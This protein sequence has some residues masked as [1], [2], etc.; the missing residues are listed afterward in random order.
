MSDKINPSGSNNFTTVDLLP[1]YYQTDD[2]KKF[3]QATLDQ[4]A[5]KGT[6]K[7]V[8][9]YIGRKN[10]KSASGK[11]IYVNAVNS[12][13]QN[14]QLEPSIVIKDTSDSVTF[15]K[16][17]QD[18]IN[19][20]DIFGGNTTNHER[21]NRQE[22]YSWDPHIDWDKFV[23]FQQYYWLPYGPDLVA[24]SGQQLN[25][26]STYTVELVQS[27]ANT[28]DYLFT[29]NGI[30]KDPTLTLYRGQTYYFEINSPGEPFSIKTAR[31]TG[32]S[33]RYTDGNYIDNFGVT[34]GTIKFTVPLDSPDTL[35][36]VSEQDPDLGGL[37]KFA[38]IDENTYI[39]VAADILGKKTYTLSNGTALSNGMKVSF[40]GNVTPASYATGE[41][42]VE[43]VGTAIK[44]VPTSI[45]EI[46]SSYTSDVSVLFDSTLFDQYPF[47]AADS[48]AGDSDYIVIN[49]SSADRNP[50]SRYNRWFHKD[51]IAASAAYNN[52]L[53]DL[54]QAKRAARPIIEFEANLK[55]FNFGSIAIKDV[56][57]IDTYTKD[58]FTTIEGTAGYNIDGVQLTEGMRVMFVADDDILV[59]NNIYKVHFVNLQNTGIGVPQIQL[60]LEETPVEN[61]TVIIRSGTQYQGLTFWYTG[62]EW[63]FSQQKTKVNQ[64]PL[65]DLYDADLNSFS[66]YSGSTFKGTKLFSYTE[67]TS[68]VVDTK[69]GFKLSYQN[70]NNIG[71]ILFTFN[72]LTD[73]FEY[74]N[75]DSLVSKVVNTGYLLKLSF[76]NETT[77]V[78]GWQTSQVERYQPAVRVYKDSNKVNDFA[79]DIYDNKADLADLEV[80]VYVNGIRIDSD[81]WTI[82]DTVNYKQIKLATDIS[83][84][85]VLTIKAFARQP[86]NENGY[87]ELPINLQNNPL[88]SD[89]ANFTL[90]EVTD[91]VNSIVDNIQERFVGV[92]SGSNNLRDLGNVTPYG[93][94]FV[95][96]S[97][98][99][100]L[101]LYHITSEQ[102]N[103]VKAIEKS[104][105]DYGKFKRNFLLTAFQLGEDTNTVNQVDTILQKL[106]ANKTKQSP[107]YFSDMVPFGGKKE[108]TYV[109]EDLTIS[110]Y[111]LTTAFDNNVLSTQAVSVYVNGEQ[112][113]YERD[114]TFTTT[115]YVSISKTLVEGDN[116][117]IYEYDSTDGSYIPSTPTK[118]GLW[119]KYEPKIYRDTSLLTPKW[120]IQCHDGSQVLAYGTYGTGGTPDYRDALILELEKRIYNNLQVNYDSSIFDIYKVIPGYY[121]D[122]EY[123]IDEFNTAIAPS[124]YKW[125]TLAGQDFS[126]P[127]EFIQ[128]NTFTY[129]FRN[130]TAP[131][132]RPLPGYW[133]GIY[134]WVYD[135]DRPNICPWE[136]LGFTEEPA[137]WQSVYGPAPY[138]SNNSIMW[139]D[140]ASGAVKE[141]G[142]SVEYRTQFAR[143]DLIN[144]I[145]VDESG[146]LVSP[147]V[148]R[149]SS[150][151]FTTDATGNYVAG[152][153]GPVEAAWRR[154][155]YYSFS[156]LI[157]SMLLKPAY[158]FATCLDRS[159]TIR[160][161]CGQLVYKDTGLRVKPADIVLPSIYTSSTRKY[162]AGIINYLVDL[163]TFNNVQY[164]TDY[165]YNLDNL[166]VKLSYRIAGFTSKENLNLILD[167]KNPSS[168]GNVFVPQENFAIVYNSSSPIRK[169][170]YSGVIV[171]RVHDGFEIKGY[172]TSESYFKYCPP[173]QQGGVSVNVGGIS[174]PFLQWTPNKNYTV[175]QI[176]YANGRYYRTV[177]NVLSQDQFDPASFTLIPALP[178]V[179][180]EDAVF[181]KTWDTDTVL[182]LAYGSVLPTIQS[183]VDF[184]LGYGEYLKSQGFIFDSFNNELSQVTNWETSAKEFMFWTT[185]KWSTGQDKWD[186]WTPNT[187]IAYGAIVKY[188]NDY[189]K[190]LVNSRGTEEFVEENFEK[191]EG[192]STIG[193]AVISLSPAAASLT[194]KSELSVADDINNPFNEYEIFKVD[195]TGLNPI[196]LNCARQ[197]NLVTY[198][199]DGTGTIYN[200]SFYLVQ[201][202]QVLIL[203]N[204]TVFNDVLYHPESGYRQE[205]IKLAG[206]VSS[207]WFGGFEVPGFIFDRAEVKQWAQ[208][209]DYALGDIVQSQGFYYSA[210]GFIPGTAEFEAKDWTQITKPSPKLLP[211]WNYKANQFEDFYDLENDSFDTGQQQ[212]SQ[213]LV[214]YQP[215][216]YLSNIIQDEISEFQ[217][218]QG[219]IREKGTQNSLNKLFDV[220]SASNKESLS[221]YEE[222]A[223]RVGQYGASKA[224]DAVEFVIE[225]PHSSKHSLGY[226]LTQQPS[227]EDPFVVNIA[228]NDVYLKP[229]GYNSQPWPTNNNQ[230][231]YLRT[232]GHVDSS[233]NVIQLGSIDDI[234]KVD[235]KSLREGAYVWTSFDKTSWNIFRFTTS[236]ISPV[237]VAYDASAKSIT[238][239]TETQLDLAM[240]GQYV[241]ISQVDFAGFYKVTD[242]QLTSFTV[243]SDAISIPT[244]EVVKS[245][246]EIFR[247][248][249]VRANSIDDANSIIKSYTTI[250]SKIWVDSNA[251]GKWATLELQSIY[252]QNK[253]KK[254]YPAEN[255]EHG[256]VVV[257]NSEGTLAAVT[258]RVGQVITYEKQ[259]T[260]WVFK[261]LIKQGF[262]YKQE[263]ELENFN[264]PDMFAEALAMSHDGEFLAIGIPRA[265]KLA[266]ITLPNGNV[267]CD[268]SATNAT[269]LQTGVVSVYQK[270][271]YNEYNLLFSI[272]S[273]DNIAD[274]QF[275]SSL[276]FGNNSLF[277]GSKGN[278]NYGA[279]SAVF[280]LRLTSDTWLLKRPGI[281]IINGASAGFGLAI[282]VTRDNAVVAISA[283]YV[284]NVY[285]YKLNAFGAYTLAQTITGSVEQLSIPT[286]VNGVDF[287]DTNTLV[288]GSGFKESALELTTAYVE[289]LETDST[290][291]GEGLIVDATVDAYGTIQAVHIR[292]AGNN[293]QVGDSIKI[294]NPLGNGAVTGFDL[295]IL[296]DIDFT[297]SVGTGIATTNNGSGSGLV[298][299]VAS[300]K[301]AGANIGD[302]VIPVP[303]IASYQVGNGVFAN[304]ANVFGKVFQA[305][306][307]VNVSGTGVGAK[308]DITASDSEYLV[309]VALVDALRVRGTGYQVNN[310][311]RILGTSLGGATPANDAVVT[312]NTIDGSGG[313]LTASITGASKFVPTITELSSVTFDGTVDGTTLTVN[314]INDGTDNITAYIN[315]T[316]TGST[317][318]IF[319]IA[320][321]SII[322][323]MTLSGVGVSEGT[324][325][326]SGSGNT[327]QV[328]SDQTLELMSMTAVL[329]GRL[330]VGMQLTNPVL[331]GPVVFDA[332]ITAGGTTT[333][334]GDVV[335]MT[336]SEATFTGSVKGLN[337]TLNETAP[338]GTIL[339]NMVLTATSGINAGTR[340][341]SGS[342]KQWVLDTLQTANLTTPIPSVQIIDTYGTLKVTSGDYSVGQAITVTGA[343]T[344]G[345][346]NGYTSGT[347]YYIG[348]VINSKT[349]QLTSTYAD[350]ISDAPEMEVRTPTGI[351]AVDLVGLTFDGMTIGSY[352]I[353]ANE[354][355]PPYFGT[356]TKP[357]LNF[358]VTSA[359]FGFVEVVTAGS[360]YLDAPV[361]TPN[362][363][364]LAGGTGAA[365]S[366]EVTLQL[367]QTAT[368]G[369]VFGLATNLQIQGKLSAPTIVGNILTFG[370]TTGTNNATLSE[371]MILSGG[372]VL[373]GTKVITGQG[374]IWYV[375]KSQTAT[376]TTATSPFATITGNRL[377]FQSS[378]GST[379][380]IGMAL[381]GGTVEPGTYITDGPATDGGITF[382]TVNNNQFT[383]CTTATK[384]AFFID[385]VINGT[386][387]TFDTTSGSPIEV[388]MVLSGGTVIAGT[389]IVSGSGT[390][391]VVSTPQTT[392]FNTATP[393]IMTVPGPIS[394]QLR[395]G[396]TLKGGSVTNGSTVI[397]AKQVNA[398][399][400]GTYFVTPIQTRT[401]FTVT[402]GYISPS[403]YITALGT[404]TGGVGTYTINQAPGGTPT[405]ATSMTISSPL[406]N[407]LVGDSEVN[408]I[409]IVTQGFTYKVGD[410]ITFNAGGTVGSVSTKVTS[411]ALDASIVVSSIGDGLST[412]SAGQFGAS[413]SLAPAGEYLAIGHPI[414]SGVQENEGRVV[415]YSNTGT[416]YTQYQA[417]TSPNAESGNLFGSSVAFA[418]DYKTLLV[419]SPNADNLIPTTF[420]D[421]QLLNTT[422]SGNP[423]SFDAGVMSFR[424]VTPN[425]GRINV[426][427]RYNTNWICGETITTDSNTN[428]GFGK[429]FAASETVILVGAPHETDIVMDAKKNILA[430]QLNVGNL[431][432]YEKPAGVFSWKTIHSQTD[433]VNLSRIK[434]AFLYNKTTNQLL[435]YLDTVDPILGKIPSTAEKELSYKTFYDPAVYTT[436]SEAVNIDSST[437]WLDKNVGKLWWDLR[438]SKFV[439]NHAESVGYRNSMMTTLATGASVD[440]YEWVATQFTPEEW[441]KAA[442]T[443]NGLSRGISGTPLYLDSYS[444]KQTY[445][446]FNKTFGNTYYFWVKNK[447]IVPDVAF[448][449]I[450][451]NEVSGLISNPRGNGYRFLALTG[452]DSFSLINCESYLSGTDV[453]LG[454]EY[455]LVDNTT[456]NIHSQWKLIDN[457]PSTNLPATIEEK[458]FDSLCGKDQADRPVPDLN[459]PAKVRYG[460]ESRPRQGMFV[461]SYE[462][463]KQFVERVNSVLINEQIVAQK[464]ISALESYDVAP[465]K[466]VGEYDTIVDTDAEL[467][468]VPVS[469]AKTAVITPVIENG[470]IVSVT[471]V[472]SGSGY[473]TSPTII[474]NGKGK[475]AKL[476]ANI[477]IG[478]QIT[479][480]DVLAKGKGYTATTLTVRPFS[481]LVQS[482]SFANGAWS[483]YSYSNTS[484]VWTRVKTQ[485]YDVRNYWTK[486]DW[487]ASGY[488]QFTNIDYAID[489]FAELTN[490]SPQ[491][492]Q[493]VKVRIAGS[494]GWQLLN[495]VSDVVTGD[496]TSQYEVVGIEQGTLQLS[497]N[498]YNFQSNNIGFDGSIYDTVGFD[499]TASRELRIILNTLRD[500]VLTD[501][502]KQS[503]LD[504]FFAS[505][506]YAHTEQTYIDWAFKTSFVKAQ[507]NVGELKQTVTYKNDNLANFQDYINEVVPY[508]TT[509]REYVSSYNT[510]DT[511]SSVVTDFDLPAI[512]KKGINDVVTTRVVN[513]KIE[514]NNIAIQ[515]YPWKNWLDNVGYTI[516]S[517]V[518]TDSGSGYVTA[519]TV[520]IVSNSGTGATAKAFIANGKVNRILLVTP[521]K[522]YLS[523]PEV[524]ID[525]GTTAT[526][527][528]AKAVAIIGNGV[529]RSS[530]MKIKFDRTTNTYYSIQ[531]N[532]AEVFT[533]T[534]NRTNF[535]LKWAPDVKIGA[536][537]V[538]VQNLGSGAV[539]LLR[540]DYTLTISKSTAKGY[541]SYAGIISFKTAPQA[542]ANIT[543]D[544]I[545]DI[546]LLNASDRIQ[547]FYNP[548]TG[549][550][551]KDLGQLM[552]GVDY[553]GVVVTGVDYNVAQGWGSIGYMSDLWDSY[554][555]TYNDYVVTIDSTTASSHE[556]LL[557][558]Q[559]EQLT[560]INVYYAQVVR[561]TYPA[562]GVQSI[563]QIGSN[564]TTI[565]LQSA[566]IK[567]VVGATTSVTDSSI[568]RITVTQTIAGFNYI[569]ASTANLTVDKAIVFSG[570]MFG[571]IVAGQT[572]YVTSIVNA[573]T[574]TMSISIDGE[575]F[576]LSN[577]TGAMTMRYATPNNRLIGNTASLAPNMAV[578]FS[579]VSFAGLTTNKTYFVKQV[580]S[581][582]EFTIS[583]TVNGSVLSL[584]TASGLM[585]VQEVAATGSL[586]IKLT[587]TAGLKVGD[588]LLVSIASAIADGTKITKINSSTEITISTILYGA[589]LAGT[590]I[591][592][593]RTLIAPV[594]YRYLTNTTL[595]LTEPVYAGGTLTISAPLDPIRI[596][597]ENF[598]KVWIITKTEVTTNIITTITPITFSVG[599]T[600][601]FTGTP[602]GG[603]ETDFTYYVKSI[604][605]NR[606]FTISGIANGPTYEVSTATGSLSA[607]SRSNPDAVMGTYIADGTEPKIFIPRTF[608]LPEGDLMI[609]RKSTSD[610]SVTVSD[611]DIDTA[612]DGGNLVYAT[613]TGLN[614]DDI[615][616][617]GDGYVTQTSS[618]APEEVVPGQVVDAVAIKV[619][620]RPSDG[621]ATVKSLSY[622]ADGITN[623]FNLEQFP[624]SKQAVVVKLNDTILTLG[625]DYFMDYPSKQIV[626]NVT[627][628]AGSVVTINSFGFNGTNVL[629]VDYFVTDGTTKEFITK[630]PYLDTDF[631]Y[632]VYL[633]GVAINPTLFKTDTTYESSN[634]I[635]FRFS[636]APNKLSV[637]NY[638]IVSGAQQ[639]YSIFKT[640]KLPTNGSLS[641]TLANTVGSSLPLESSVI[642]RAN[643]QI[644][645]GPNTSYFTISGNQ[646]TYTLDQSAVQP[647]SINTSDVT[648]YADGNLLQL[649]TDYSVDTSGVSVSINQAT[650]RKYTGKRLIVSI[651]SQQDYS[652][653][654]TTITFSEAYTANDYVE[655][656][657]AFKHDILQVQRTKKKA[658]SNLQFTAKT[659]NYYKYIGVLGGKIELSTTVTT[660]SQLWV[661]KNKTLLVNSVD[662]RLTPTLDSIV[663]DKAPDINDE[664][665]VIIFAGSPVR[666]GLS[667]MQFKD[668][669]NRTVYKRLSALKQDELAQDLNYYDS[670]IV[671][672]DAGN[673]DK[674]N[675]DLNKPGVIEINGERIEYFTVK[676]NTVLGQLRRGTLGTGVP[677][678]HGAGSKV[679][680]IG[681]SE[682][683]PYTDTTKTEQVTING[684]TA[685]LIIPLSFVPTKSEAWSKSPAEFGLF[686]SARIRALISTTAT[687]AT[688][689]VEHTD[690][691]HYAPAIGKY[692]TVSGNGSTYDGT[693]TV[694]DSVADDPARFT[695]TS[696]SASDINGV[697]V[698]I[699]FVIP[700]QSVA[701]TVGTYFVIS[702]AIPLEYNSAWL[703]TASTTTSITLNVTTNYGAITQL[704]TQIVSTHAVTLSYPAT[705]TGFSTTAL[706]TLSAPVYGQ[707]DNIDV[708]VGGYDES[709]IWTPNT[710]FEAEQIVTINSYTYRMTTKH[711]SG[712]TFNSAVTTLD[713]DGTTISTNVPATTVRTF[714]IGNIRLKKHPYSIYNVENAPTSP[715][716]DVAFDADFAVDGVNAELVL[717]NKLTPGTVV[718]IIRK[719]GKTWTENNEDLQVSQTKIAKFITS[720]PGVWVTGNQTTSTA[721]SLPSTT[722][723]FD[724]VNKT[725]DGDNT[726]F[727]QGT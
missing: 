600:I 725:F 181:R 190:S 132:G 355:S 573:N 501:T 656:I 204:T 724:N 35:Y 65:F 715:E 44:L 426:F 278:T 266:T 599:D 519:P 668:M 141:P 578:Q 453:V 339:P 130:H 48:Y 261:Q 528:T 458:W 543:V 306:A 640:E 619:Y 30:D 260:I 117:A 157:A 250:G 304:V 73:T 497:S 663:L 513:G 296:S 491:V 601:K 347:T 717:L 479:S 64:P 12:T 436:G 6:A 177:Y 256:S 558:Y 127:A 18:Y 85:D 299:K 385:G 221:F 195:G 196:D 13:R 271:S 182:T 212:I 282:A 413:I 433:L 5:Q 495:C 172:S 602:F 83:T 88:N 364:V 382:W 454:V 548:T 470:S 569:K 634:R 375:D 603:L 667:Y 150:G 661:T 669:L 237:S 561:N 620:D 97:G 583:E 262:I 475:G 220:L 180:G 128:S 244:T 419:Y 595:Q 224:F 410:Q 354:I 423:T 493:T 214:G 11:D 499:F 248:Q 680:D 49:R 695:P 326:V 485:A 622:I 676:N 93:T 252:N 647:Y 522:G 7:K 539:T 530:L 633:D 442:D 505:V 166:S 642:V 463:L 142:K 43:G 17:Y 654:G 368:P 506:R 188:N 91:H 416:A 589:L 164:Y 285:V 552:T 399:G 151:V 465:N 636:I 406:I 84:S 644:L 683:I 290:G 567:S 570:T 116:I 63:K 280:E 139:Q 361:I 107:Y 405:T 643:Q 281:S 424:E 444:I 452:K 533:G 673:F 488:S 379:P 556:F 704:P 111:P 69:L 607:V 542:G 189:Y 610:G 8:N 587:N 242:V 541:T 340:I 427:D 395:L 685:D 370:P 566:I 502:L 286:N 143:P 380:A 432:S 498:L 200:A 366:V 276:A 131:D 710:V 651:V 664:F 575:A 440:I 319:E 160:N 523:A 309:S 631:T 649:I 209:H 108:L 33:D 279:Q 174:A 81:N 572:Y 175:G 253:I 38:N 336:G 674:P 455:W 425:S 393:V 611:N 525:G 496:W 577:G 477:N 192:L 586:T 218:Y 233:E 321:S 531:L 476:K 153:V 312:V 474:V 2:N 672:K 257:M 681:P 58:V 559:P 112:L 258:T 303:S 70:I 441:A 574:F 9:G 277:I 123:S 289:S 408:S 397:A 79:L 472:N 199:P 365:V 658:T 615:I 40:E 565:D 330:K 119:P 358:V 367:P 469:T 719:T 298:V 687:T 388:G 387:M 342:G 553:G 478:G 660:E 338:V 484:K 371:G 263:D 322:P 613:A 332:S 418:G 623:K 201:K 227:L 456:Q 447:V 66:T 149:F 532:E 100:S 60:V 529:T 459:L 390:S 283:P 23:N 562:D 420:D 317:L 265:G 323:G 72:L 169:L 334:Q 51:T 650:Y 352:P 234:V 694:V 291:T 101:A 466:F 638:L 437:A 520:R 655:V 272:A 445:D 461:N 26:V 616:V 686:D 521:G 202:E 194:F 3:L 308:F 348:K 219:M 564:Y 4:L 720:V 711:L 122:S 295:K 302:I 313:I 526:S 161:I 723:S 605:T 699:T 328:S 363:A 487:Y 145:P 185:Q 507:H 625:V 718:T 110:E 716:G 356:G 582:T 105:D 700:T 349:I 206:F 246:M 167:S 106:A 596:D 55:L 193:S 178:I 31:T 492:G 87:Y 52:K 176:V 693:Y 481:V 422:F 448:R 671:V 144:H 376:C 90:G 120:M 534:G 179:G 606:T 102:N 53:V 293:Y 205:R 350:A 124:F 514:A 103:I 722:T 457:N 617:D 726:T 524:I 721:S 27:T 359:T 228:Y 320:G 435:T 679:Q 16:D 401:T 374:N 468:L 546:S 621:S 109:V 549:Q 307:G 697:A 19:Q 648:V 243:S 125:A 71:D 247:L 191:L 536:S 333:F 571:N 372:T 489:T 39:D 294:V 297:G 325:I 226:H 346:I 509:V 56:D 57:L 82:V 251:A 22:F 670:T 598:T 78:N 555:N 414:Y 392:T 409:N 639:T 62:T 95:Q 471:V 585:N 198:T 269:T 692:L 563:Y 20:L 547:F 415:V 314:S 208:W 42:Y 15:F 310:T 629:D 129:N 156:V 235:I 345:V 284:G 24:I 618:G 301:T 383:T 703:C 396:Q 430:S 327:W 335:T 627:P 446:A 628:T 438:T 576:I 170:S 483:I 113:L 630:A 538:K 267:V 377:T 473:Q 236:R 216:Q 96:H 210:N 451:A 535:A 557:P 324:T 707:S 678:V 516:T 75:S 705:P 689:A 318:T 462:A 594:D 274:Q 230:R 186:D 89:M 229:E 10:A 449:K 362:L 402:A 512:Y 288:G 626:I 417:I 165:Q 508:R 203:D 353:P 239:E 706:T 568:D 662:Y 315:A 708:F 99:T 292:E 163:L 98:P 316:I 331:D 86:I 223:L 254:P 518:I 554:E 604:L 659:P 171:T 41:Y 597:D 637:L 464:N 690:G 540:D 657:S 140:L 311:I 400:T 114:Y 665:E 344:S 428:D 32:V 245:Q 37:I 287:F 407:T 133:R 431:Y 162:T 343:L 135:T 421:D 54:D 381:T 45:L 691:P 702:G 394:G 136:M 275:G 712:T 270:S 173:M 215:R 677:T 609:F 527:T 675:P 494:S 709:T 240:L 490:I 21:I 434:Q 207:E 510:V 624:N 184:L 550:L 591:T 593:Q 146:N 341:V 486:V 197:G 389:Y 612:L 36:Y 152:D 403:T 255:M 187:N 249:P 77:Y 480:V 384:Q 34:N 61:T 666:P 137:W 118:L 503:Y 305:V 74:K 588:A 412:S 46:I 511:S 264:T 551:G 68:G 544:Y 641:Y 147:V 653:V 67:N 467:R 391:W 232:P 121:R 369:A 94:K 126:K 698:S 360:G 713:A 217:F 450:S 645:T 329:P 50:W 714:F 159:R 213:H 378:S 59:K 211:N 268:E 28:K 241:G 138:T 429:S 373:A 76:A 584:P 504:L 608:N 231:Y 460:V 386:T 701:P 115:G 238:V 482:D 25:V 104:R 1:K 590:E 148:S 398:D 439:D 652:I 168:A 29:P 225:E 337:L 134:R 684:S 592:F 92:T 351:T 635:G 646:Y 515:S 517:L 560:Q 545:K 696:I 682:T 632:L 581:S 259:G 183:V 155:S 47:A 411:V 614:P 300:T 357:T 154:S 14:Y 273:G 537:S 222:W 158:T 443:P 580:V 688:F 579:G 500:N 404:G 80:R 727:D